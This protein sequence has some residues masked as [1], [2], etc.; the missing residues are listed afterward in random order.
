MANRLEQIAEHKKK[1]A[2]EKQDADVARFAKK[3]ADEVLSGIGHVQKGEISGAIEDLA[4]QVALAVVNSKEVYND[5]LK[6]S[7]S[8]LVAATKKN[9]PDLT[10]IML[11]NKEI[12]VTLARF[13][14]ALERL[15]LSPQITLNGLDAEQLKK[16]VD[17]I[18]AK[19]PTTSKRDVTVS[20]QNATADKYLNVRLTD[21]I[22]FYRAFSSGGRE[23]SATEA[24]QDA[25]ISALATLVAAQKTD[26]G[27]NDQEETGTYKYFGFE[28]PSG[29]WKITRKTLSDNSFRYATG[30][31]DYSTAWT[32]RATQIYDTYGVTF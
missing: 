4:T 3:I 31:S 13:E 15:E 29:A 32:N 2:A 21:G 22:G 25:I 8:E 14:R 30:P 23:G 6:G 26:W 7:F 9:K 10:P 11:T 5:D 27:L 17:K 28:S 19:L 1:V 12:G 18:L 20:Y 24:K 16:E